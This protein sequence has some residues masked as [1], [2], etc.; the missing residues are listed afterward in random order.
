M[1][2]SRWQPSL[3]IK[4]DPDWLSGIYLGNCPAA[5]GPQSYVVFIVCP[6]RPPRQPAFSVQRVL[7][8]RPTTAGRITLRSMTMERA[9]GTGA[10]ACRS[11]SMSHTASIVRTSWT[12]SAPWAAATSALGIPLRLL[13]RGARLRRELYLEPR[14][15]PRSRR[16]R[17]SWGFQR[18]PWEHWTMGVLAHVVAVLL[19]PI[20]EGERPLR[21]DRRAPARARPCPASQRRRSRAGKP[22]HRRASAPCDRIHPRPEARTYRSRPVGRRWASRSPSID[23][24]CRLRP[25][26]SVAF[27]DGQDLILAGGLT[28]AGTTGS[29]FRI[30]L[31]GGPITPDGRL[32]HRVS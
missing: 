21:Q 22:R 30:P 32:V 31:D 12:R 28:A 4:I 11:A 18:G 15:P 29:V 10:A 27:A 17:S 5:D 20:S 1:R 7:T 9:I 14:H 25:R 23:V 8:G 16:P 2:D 13:A 6:G 26:G 3:T 24:D 19:E